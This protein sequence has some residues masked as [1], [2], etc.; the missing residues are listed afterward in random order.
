MPHPLSILHQQ[1][2][3]ILPDVPTIGRYVPWRALEYR[4]LCALTHLVAKV[5]GLEAFEFIHTFGDAH[6][7]ENHM[8][9]VREQL[10]REPF[11]LPTLVID[12]SVAS[13]EELSPEQIRLVGYISTTL[14]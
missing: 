13:L 2:A 4:L 6:I 3:S 14:V 9:Q 5:T 8:E 11:P 1:R 12:D 7:Y 10:S